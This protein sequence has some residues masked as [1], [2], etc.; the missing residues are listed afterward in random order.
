[1]LSDTKF[2]LFIPATEFQPTVSNVHFKDELKK[3]RQYFIFNSMGGCALGK[4]NSRGSWYMKLS[5]YVG[6]GSL[7]KFNSTGGVGVGFLPNL[8]KFYI[9]FVL[10]L[11]IPM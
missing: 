5:Y 10:V 3:S 8:N 1:M 2:L 4:L 6:G 7:W 11:T 9:E